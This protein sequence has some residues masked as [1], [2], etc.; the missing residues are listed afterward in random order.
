MVSTERVLAYS[1]LEPE[2]SL[3]THPD[4]AKPSPDWPSKGRIELSDLTYCHSP[5]GPLVLKGISL[6]ILPAEKV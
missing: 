1:K 2:A 3:E 6:T 5:E 4:S